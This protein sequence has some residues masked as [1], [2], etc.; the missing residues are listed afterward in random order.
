MTVCGAMPPPPVGLDIVPVVPDVATLVRTMCD[1]MSDPFDPDAAAESHVYLRLLET[2]FERRK[3]IRPG[4]IAWSRGVIGCSLLAVS[5]HAAGGPIRASPHIGQ[6]P[7][8]I[9]ISELCTLDRVW[10]L[11]SWSD[12]SC[13]ALSEEVALS[14]D[15]RT[16]FCDALVVHQTSFPEDISQEGLEDTRGW[17]Q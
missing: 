11:A 16:A 9:D 14:A 1:R 8:T 17:K 2:R 7:V 10:R 12:S 6:R 15:A 3:L 4:H 13:H 5:R